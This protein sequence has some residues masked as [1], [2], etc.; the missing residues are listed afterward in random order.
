MVQ[1]RTFWENVVHSLI[2]SD[3][4]TY[5]YVA[6]FSNYEVWLSDPTHIHPCAQVVWPVVGQEITNSDAGGG[7]QGIQIIPGLYQI[8]WYYL[9]ITTEHYRYWW[10]NFSRCCVH[11]WLVSQSQSVKTGDALKKGFNSEIR[12]ICSRLKYLFHGIWQSTA[13]PRMA[14]SNLETYK[15]QSFSPNFNSSWAYDTSFFRWWYNPSTGK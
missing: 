5:F 9:W 4:P 10:S 14:L 8:W 3:P 13:K 12:V 2:Y 11:C 15:D 1:V 7:L 6:R